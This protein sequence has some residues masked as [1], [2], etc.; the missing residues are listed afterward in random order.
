MNAAFIRRM[1]TTIALG[2]IV[3]AG[4]ADAKSKRRIRLY[5]LANGQISEGF[6]TQGFI[7]S[8]KGDIE[9]L[10]PGGERAQGEYTTVPNGSSSWGTVYASVLGPDGSSASGSAFRS[11]YSMSMKQRGSAVVAGDHGTVVECEYVVSGYSGHGSGAC[12][13]NKGGL[14]RAMF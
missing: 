13:D 9:L 3:F 10:L 1:A 2:A 4:A 6:F 8:G 7:P 14:Y 5:N 12:K 11:G